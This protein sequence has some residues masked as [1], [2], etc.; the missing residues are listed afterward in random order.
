[1]KFITI[2]IAVLV[3]ANYSFGQ[4]KQGTDPGIQVIE[5]SFNTGWTFNYFQ[6]G[7][8]SSG[9]E[10]PGFNDSRWPIISL[11]H[12]WNSFETTGE[13]EP[14]TRSPGETGE[15]FWWTG[16]G[17]YRKHFVMNTV[18]TLQK[19]FIEFE[20][21]QKY[22]KVWINGIYAGDHLGGY[23][24]FD[25]DIT[26]RVRPEADNL[27]AVAVSYNQKDEFLV[28]PVAPATRNTSC[29]IYRDVRI[30]TRNRLYIPMQGSPDHEGGVYVTTPVISD[31][32]AVANIRT[33][34]RNDY[35]EPRSC[36]LQTSVLDRNK[37][38][39]Q[40]IKSQAEISPGETYMFAQASKP[41]RD[42]HLWSPSDPYLY[43]VY[44]EVFDKKDLSDTCSTVFGF[45]AIR[46]GEKPGE[47]FVNNVRTELSGVF[48]HVEFPWIGDA[49]PGWMIKTDYDQLAD[50][51]SVNF[52]RITGYPGNIREFEQGDMKGLLMEEDFTALAEHN[53]SDEDIRRQITGIFRRDRNHP[54]LISWCVSDT[55][56][57]L[58]GVPDILLTDSSRIL[59][60]LGARIV[61]PDS[62]FAYKGTEKNADKTVKPGEAARIV[63]NSSHRSIPADRGSVAVILADITDSEGNRLEGL[64]NCLTWK[65][66]G[67]AELAGPSL[68]LSYADSSRSLRTGRY[69]STPAMNLIRSN[70]KPGEIRITVF[71]AGLAS[72]SCE[73]SAV[74]DTES[75][76]VIIQPMPR[77]EGRKPVTKT[78][79]VTE[80]IEEIP[81][82]I[83]PA[84]EDI[85]MTADNKK[86]LYALI[87][88]YIKQR[89]P[90]VDTTTIELVTLA[91]LLAGQLFNNSGKMSS[92][93]YNFNAS[94]YNTCRL[95]ASYI[96]S[97]KLPS[98]YKEGLRTYYSKTVI[99]GGIEKNPGDEMNWMNWIPSGGT[100]VVVRN[101]D[102]VSG[103]K[104][105]V[106]TDHTDLPG[107]IK[108]VY[109]QFG[110]FSVYARDRALVFINK[111]NPSIH[112]SWQDDPTTVDGKRKPVYSAEKGQPIL[113]P[114]YKFISE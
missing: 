105:V 25:F 110:K 75:M 32:E 68:Y 5:S 93:D 87:R 72:G 48:R 62:F 6:S 60:A 14:F 24:S 7:A 74:E 36:V 58:R 73:I 50:N 78:L 69:I 96:E 76:S 103:E 113:I 49:V 35:S 102:R 86:K 27:L 38:L 111:M 46:S 61:S 88:N 4:K 94:H 89:N 77:E 22:C 2:L 30:V 52:V 82:E 106:Y 31:N 19:V 10:S 54:S 112:V 44:S 18:D 67:P 98:L 83:S 1:M 56:V 42:I 47:V 104:G 81:R 95:I 85:N 51:K 109:P 37:K 28:H 20:G 17:W 80:R 107:I 114:E 26:S 63:L 8:V 100:V 23:G 79:L 101:D 97:T 84:G 66:E 90:A 92:A 53:F 59:R 43:T 3:S 12:T 15:T 13:A 64:T 65:A 39:I 21:V 108:A 40:S 71:S 41:L 16:W 33:W 29:G 34:V 70:G 11:P 57:S 55:A 9:Y 45:R 91:D 99:V